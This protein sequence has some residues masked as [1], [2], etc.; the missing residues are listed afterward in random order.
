[1]LCRSKPTL[2]P[3]PS[4]GEG[5]GG[6]GPIGFVCSGTMSPTLSKAIGTGY[7]PVETADIGS[8]IFIDIR[9]KLRLAEIVQTPF[10]RKLHVSS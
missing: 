2:A 8:K 5:E 3:S 1:M 7:V 10:Y 6:G 9:G 4:M